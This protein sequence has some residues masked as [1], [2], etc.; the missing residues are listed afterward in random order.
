MLIGF[1]LIKKKR[2]YKIKFQV[3]IYR[4]VMSHDTEE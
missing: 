1:M 4:G 3:R 2:V